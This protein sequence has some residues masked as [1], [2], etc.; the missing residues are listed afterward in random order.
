MVTVQSLTFLV[1]AI[2]VASAWGK[3][4]LYRDEEV[5]KIL[6]QL[7]DKVIRD[8]FEKIGL[9]NSFMEKMLSYAGSYC[10]GQVL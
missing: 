2:N 3:K 8:P 7:G 6:Y 10:L 1:I 9:F 4:S 5:R